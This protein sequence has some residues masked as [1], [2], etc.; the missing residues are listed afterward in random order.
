MSTFA[1]VPRKVARASKAPNNNGPSFTQAPANIPAVDKGKGREI[2]AERPPPPEA[3]PKSQYSDED[4]TIL[5]C[6]SLS[7]YRLWSDPDLRRDIEWS[8]RTRS[9]DGFFP[10]SY[11]LDSPCPLSSTHAS[12]TLI[13]KALRAHATDVV[14]V[15]MAIP[16]GDGPG[17]TRGNFEIRPKFWDE[18]VYPVSREGWESRTVYVENIPIKYKTLPGFCRFILG[19]LP[20]TTTMATH[21]R[22]QGINLPSHHSDDPGTEPKPKSFALITLAN[23]DDAESLLT[24]WPWARQQRSTQD[25]SDASEALKFG[26]RTLSKARWD[27][28]NAQYLSY[29]AKLLADIQ[30]PDVLATTGLPTAP[31]QDRPEPKRQ[32]SPI[33]DPIALASTMSYPRN[34]LVFVRHIH[35]ET[36]KTTLRNFFA[37]AVDVKEAIDYVDFNKGMDSC[38]LRLTT[39]PHAKSFVDHFVR[40]QIL[41]ASGLDDS[42]C[43]A[44]SGQGNGKHVEAELVLGKREEVYW[45]KV[46]EK[47]CQQAVQKA[48]GLGAA[49]LAEDDAGGEGRRRQRKKQ[50]R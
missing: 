31:P 43:P 35:P 16:S 9:N 47:V 44:S 39:P 29:R 5:L 14:D 37:K 2:P 24:T 30:E 22:I 48:L 15:R 25:S 26:F 3:P 18:A 4:Y 32:A 6:L 12:E 49:L 8:S 40:N 38:Y 28:L 41:H 50:K 36:N 20:A 7:K 17:K 11:L 42:G 19:L 45:E 34:C 46:P 10:L 1:F 27:E 23:A 13:V 21:N 33:D